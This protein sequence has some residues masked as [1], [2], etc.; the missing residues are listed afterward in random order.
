MKA[1][2]DRNPYAVGLV[3]VVII[4][5]LVAGAFAVGQ[6]HLLE[7]TYQ[8]K[9]VFS[10]A[11]GAHPGDTVR[12]AGVKV[13]RITKIAPDH[14][15]GNVI[16]EMVVNKG[17]HL[18]PH[19][20]ADVALE[21]LLGSKFIRLSG[22]VTRPYLEDTPSA[23]RVI[24][25]DRT[26][27]PFDVFDLTK[28]ATRN[29]QAT[30]TAKLNELITQLGQITQGK[31]QDVATLVN[32]IATI[33]DA[34]NVRDAQLRDLL[35]KA[36]KLSGTLADKDATLAALIDQ[37][38]GVL[39]LVQRRQADI[40]AGLRSGN[41]AVAEA[42]GVL[43][44]NR[45]TLDALLTTLHP[46]FD[47]IGQHQTDINRSLSVIGPGAL[48]LA[49]APAHGPWADIYIRDIGPSVIC[50]LATARGLAC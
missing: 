12:V 48:G 5:A 45:T 28:V 20:H 47:T 23:Q 26:T 17:V 25:R 39:D 34:I 43:D 32:S 18:G 31:Q 37:S 44:R 16:I 40:A 13:G 3:S 21:T 19:T 14:K 29:I 49:K 10:D 11:A 30:D 35:D 46:A 22:P 36:D 27:T 38:Q 50:Q 2:R 8:V 4:G 15:A 9:G 33:S 7:H 24:P 6:F 41:R 42:A 1:F